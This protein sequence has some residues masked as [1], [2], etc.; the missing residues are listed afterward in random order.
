V[1]QSP[2]VTFSTLSGYD[3]EFGFD[4]GEDFADNSVPKQGKQYET[5]QIPEAKNKTKT[6]YVPWLTLLQ[7]Q[8]E[9]LKTEISK[10]IDGDNIYL[11][12]SKNLTANYDRAQNRL[13]VTNN[14]LDNSFVKPVYIYFYRDDKYELQKRMLIG[15]LAVVGMERKKAIDVQV[16][17]F[18]K[19]STKIK[20]KLDLDKLKTQLNDKSLNQAFLSYN[21]LPNPVILK[22]DLSNSVKND[23]IATYR[24]IMAQCNVNFNTVY[25][26]MT[27]IEFAGNSGD[28]CAAGG[29]MG[30]NNFAVMWQV[31]PT[32]C[33]KEDI[34][35]LIAH[36]FG[37]TLGLKE[38]YNEPELGTHDKGFS[39][40]NYMDYSTSAKTL[41]RKMFFKKQIEIMLKEIKDEE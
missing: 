19:D 38:A 7:G 17:Y 24:A 33:A 25:V 6:L 32:K 30:N 41:I 1:K 16:I 11:E 34:Y 9:T 39:R 27:E 8:T 23:K 3:G 5:I 22:D 20:N 31:D 4:D 35:K 13:S 12:T 18:A 14:N 2:Y 10:T 37:H 36:E 29:V 15:K 40:N 21:I 28:G 26:V